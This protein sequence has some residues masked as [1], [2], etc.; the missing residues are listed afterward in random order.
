MNGESELHLANYYLWLTYIF[1]KLKLEL[2]LF[3][4]SVRNKLR[5][6]LQL[7]TY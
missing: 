7:W 4:P 1:I 2:S 5:F 3:W 6:D